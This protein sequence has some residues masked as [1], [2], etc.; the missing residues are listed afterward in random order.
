MPSF[1]CDFCITHLWFMLCTARS[2]K[3]V[4]RIFS[5]HFYTYLFT[6][7]PFNSLTFWHDAHTFCPKHATT[8][9]RLFN[10]APYLRTLAYKIFPTGNKDFFVITKNLVLIK[11]FFDGVLIFYSKMTTKSQ[12][13]P[14]RCDARTFF[15]NYATL[16]DARWRSQI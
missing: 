3:Y 13:S 11:E 6:F 16:A 2:I 8:L 15:P 7:W 5:P 14:L 12:H 1:S 10:T 9:A 4:Q